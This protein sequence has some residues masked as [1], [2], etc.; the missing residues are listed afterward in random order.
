VTWRVHVVKASERGR[1]PCGKAVIAVT[2][3]TASGAFDPDSV[4]K[5]AVKATV[6][7]DK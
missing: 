2:M 3:L 7:I 4:S 1:A 5:N 6:A